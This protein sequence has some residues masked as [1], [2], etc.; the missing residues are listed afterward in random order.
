MEVIFR[1]AKALY[2]NKSTP[3]IYMLHK[4]IDALDFVYLIV[5]HSPI[6]LFQLGHLAQFDS[7]IYHLAII[8]TFY[9]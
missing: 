8:D 4:E 5:K 1:F 3:L 7:F 6:T 9:L 2:I